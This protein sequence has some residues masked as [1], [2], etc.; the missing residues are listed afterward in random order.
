MVKIGLARIT[1]TDTNWD[2][3]ANT[4]GALAVYVVYALVSVRRKAGR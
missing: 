3:V 1:L 4:L 2:I